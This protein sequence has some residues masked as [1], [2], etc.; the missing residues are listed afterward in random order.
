MSTFE[1]VFRVFGKDVKNFA[2]IVFTYLKHRT[3]LGD[4]LGI[5]QFKL[6]HLNYS[7][8]ETS[9]CAEHGFKQQLRNKQTENMLYKLIMECAG[10]IMIIDNNAHRD[11][12]ESQVNAIIKEIKRIKSRSGNSCFGATTKKVFGFE[13]I[14]NICG[15]F[16]KKMDIHRKLTNEEKEVSLQDIKP[17]TGMC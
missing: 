14:D 10:N 8:T 7:N 9:V 3:A 12:C 2:F 11:I 16:S 6:R 15:L 5:T 4:F 13:T 17:Y 1:T